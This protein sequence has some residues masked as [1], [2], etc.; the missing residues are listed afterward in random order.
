M[1]RWKSLLLNSMAM[2]R[3]SFVTLTSIL[4]RSFRWRSSWPTT[5]CI[6]SKNNNSNLT[7]PLNNS[8]VR[9]RVVFLLLVQ[10]T[11]D[12]CMFYKFLDFTV[13]AESQNSIV[14]GQ[15]YKFM[16][17]PDGCSLKVGYLVGWKVLPFEVIGSGMRQPGS[18]D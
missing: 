18:A 17:I 13:S 11:F 1:S 5:G 2:E 6:T 10:L 4:T 12:P 9:R 15:V 14:P 7:L 8:S 3:T 16:R